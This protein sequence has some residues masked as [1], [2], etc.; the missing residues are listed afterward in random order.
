MP[1]FLLAAFAKNEKPDLSAKERI[2]LGKAVGEMLR[3]Y[4]SRK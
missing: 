2:A 3:N 1:V 4:R